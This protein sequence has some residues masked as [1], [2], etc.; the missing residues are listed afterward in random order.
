MTTFVQSL[1]AGLSEGSIFALMALGMVLVLR[2]TTI[3]NFGHAVNFM[4]APVLVLFMTKA[5][6]PLL[7]AS[8]I[9]L[10]AVFVLGLVIERVTIQPLFNA[11]HLPQVF[12]TVAVL[13][14]GEGVVRSLVA[15][16]QRVPPMMGD[17]VLRVGGVA[18]NPQYLLS[19]AVLVVCL[20]ALVVVFQRTSTGRVLRATTESVRGASLVGINTKR[21][22]LITWA[23][24]A[25]LGAVAGLL[26]A[27][28]YL[29]S[30]DMGA[31]AANMAFVGMALGGFGS[32][33]GAVLGS[34]LVGV[35]NVLASTYVSTT[36]G[37]GAGFL[38]IMLVLLV[39]PQGILGTPSGARA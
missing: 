12:A 3:L 25:V 6:I 29:V 36:L 31:R 4:A 10:V 37:D 1:I 2:A 19:I 21:V 5:G 16:P 17:A 35:T 18:L 15:V 20:V 30:A 34:L 32:I 8:A 13:F 22:F 28:V 38:L 7:V 24:A 27:P 9:A 11:E 39:R 26:A 14:I 33:P 23:V